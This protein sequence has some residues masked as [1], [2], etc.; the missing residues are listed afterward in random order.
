[1]VGLDHLGQG[2]AFGSDAEP[3][4]GLPRARRLV[5][6]RLPQA[7]DAPI[8][9]CRAEKHRHYLR[10]FEGAGQVLIN[11]LLR[12]LGFLE[13]LFE[14]LIVK[15]GKLLDQAGAGRTFRVPEAAGQRD[16]VRGLARPIAVSAFA[17]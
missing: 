14:Q 5:A 11:F 10:P 15:I 16:Q 3:S 6:Q 4:G 13:Q 7:A 9:E 8:R 17:D 2:L 1:M 12:R